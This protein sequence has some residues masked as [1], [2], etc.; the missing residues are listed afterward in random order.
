MTDSFWK[1]P[2]GRRFTRFYP[3][4]IF[5]VAAIWVDAH[6]VDRQFGDE[7]RYLWYARNI[8]RGYYG[9]L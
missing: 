6:A 9:I 5:V 2:L 3:L 4:A 8:L 7:W 1:T